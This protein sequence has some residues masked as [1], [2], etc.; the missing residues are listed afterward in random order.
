MVHRRW[1]APTYEPCD[2][3]VRVNL[4][5][6]DGAKAAIEFA[7]DDPQAHLAVKEQLAACKAFSAIASR[8]SKGSEHK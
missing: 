3:G 7:L 1:F 8:Y 4:G 6:H 5:S 2:I